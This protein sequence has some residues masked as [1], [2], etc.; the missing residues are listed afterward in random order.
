MFAP[1]FEKDGNRF[2]FADRWTRETEDEAR[3]A[4]ATSLLDQVVFGMKYTG[5]VLDDSK[6][7]DA[8]EADMGAWKVFA[9]S[10]PIFDE[11]AG[12]MSHA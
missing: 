10:G 9:L 1:V 11:V 8:V 2:V 6:P 7:V 12:V 4:G 3:Y 5:D